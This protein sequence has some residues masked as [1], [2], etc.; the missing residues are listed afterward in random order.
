VHSECEKQGSR[1]KEGEGRETRVAAVT[2]SLTHRD[3]ESSRLNC[4]IIYNITQVQQGNRLY[5]GVN[6]KQSH[7]E[8][9][10]SCTCYSTIRHTGCMGR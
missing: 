4:V 7:W 2:R 10:Q 6:D 5:Y 3:V 8:G 9:S 1:A